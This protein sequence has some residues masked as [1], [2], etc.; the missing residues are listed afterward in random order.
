MIDDEDVDHGH[1]LVPGAVS[2]AF[3]DGFT[4]YRL[5]IL[6]SFSFTWADRLHLALL[7]SLL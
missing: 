5:F 7:I 4:I 6:A 3:T 1:S 2:F